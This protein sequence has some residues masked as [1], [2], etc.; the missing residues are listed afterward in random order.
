MK[1]KWKV[2]HNY[3]G[4]ETFIQVYRLRDVQK[5]DHSG[6]REYAS[7]IFETDEEAQAFA[8]YLNAEGEWPV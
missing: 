7:I 1:G 2:S 4:G 3:A 8:D 6:N 5:V